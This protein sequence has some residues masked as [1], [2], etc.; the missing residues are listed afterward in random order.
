MNWFRRP[1]TLDD[2]QRAELPTLL[3][4]LDRFDPGQRERLESLT[5]ALVHRRDWTP[6]R[7]FDLTARMQLHVAAHAAV[8]G[9]GIDEPDPF[10]NVESIVVHPSTMV[11]RRPR[12]TPMRGVVTEAP[13]A[14]LGHTTANGPVFVSW[15]AVRRDRATGA[16]DVVL[17]EF[18]HKLDAATHLLDGTPRMDTPAHLERWV[19]VCTRIHRDLRRGAPDPVLRSYAATNPTEFFAVATEAFF[20]R[21]LD[22]RHVH[23]DLHEVFVDFF[24]QDPA[25]VDEAR[26]HVVTIADPDED[27]ERS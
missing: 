24:G 18:A 25:A 16:G 17:H 5:A 11:D 2:S 22:L 10:A 19:R 26:G 20:V 15:A 27:A 6:A 12:P 3:G 7:G 9:V 4:R 21:P 1:A 23:P 8:L 14:L 13:R